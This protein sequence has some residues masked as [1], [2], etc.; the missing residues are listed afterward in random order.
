MVD[1]VSSPPVLIVGAGISGLVLAQHLQ[2]LGVPFEIFDRD[3]AIDARSGGWGLTLHWALPALRHL[4]PAHIVNQ[5][6]HTFVNKDA[7]SRGDVGSF[8]FFNLQSGEALYSVP[9]EERIR[10]NR[11]RLRELLTSGINVHVG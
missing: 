6:P 2:H 7:S 5:F 10:V 4:L 1:F 3:S 11:G 8:Q 9:A